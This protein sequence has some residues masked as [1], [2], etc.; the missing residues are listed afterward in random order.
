[1]G[2]SSTSST[3]IGTGGWAVLTGADGEQ[4]PLHCVPTV[5]RTSL[6]EVKILWNLY[7]LTFLFILF[8]LFT[9]FCHN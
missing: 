2:N 5:S 1:V 6:P 4:T 7:F 9:Y 3:G 8:L